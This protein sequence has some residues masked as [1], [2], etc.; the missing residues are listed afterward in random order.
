[1]RWRPAHGGGLA[2]PWQAPGVDGHTLQEQR[3]GAGEVPDNGVGQK[4]LLY[5]FAE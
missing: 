1:M 2:V 3:T 4:T 5:I